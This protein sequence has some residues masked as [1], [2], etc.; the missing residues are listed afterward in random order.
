MDMQHIHRYHRFF[1]RHKFYLLL[2]FLILLTLVC[3]MSVYMVEVADPRSN[4]KT[5][6]DGLWWAFT[7]VSSV[8][9]GDHYPVTFWGRIIGIILIVCGV[10][11]FFVMV[12]IL[13]A[14]IVSKDE[15][16]HYKMLSKKLFGIE[17]KIDELLAQNQKQN[18]QNQEGVEK[19]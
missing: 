13:V 5:V 18:D 16:Y 17:G 6:S 2:V 14:Y 10:S 1:M 9:Y 7:T 3:G 8:G 4:L 12:S 11:T 15:T 19:Q